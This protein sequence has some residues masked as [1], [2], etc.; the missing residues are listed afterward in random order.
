MS[1]EATASMRSAPA[2]R[3]NLE[4]IR[5]ELSRLLHGRQGHLLE[6]ASGTGEHAVGI[7]PSLPGLIWHPSD[8]DPLQRASIDAHRKAANAVRVRSA[9]DLDAAADWPPEAGE[10]APSAIFC[11]NLIHISPPQVSRGIFRNAGRYLLPE[12]LL[13]LYGPFARDGVLQGEG[14]A[15]F[16]AQLRARNPDWGIRD[17]ADLVPMAE[18]AGLEWSERIRMPANNEINVFRRL[19]A[20]G[21]E[22]NGGEIT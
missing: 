6:L 18:A 4:P 5:R 17:L 10:P 21:T 22:A 7:S 12:G 8:P 2:A 11:A 3:R 19:P 14:N 9:R 15:A 20:A 16:D 1:E 13:I